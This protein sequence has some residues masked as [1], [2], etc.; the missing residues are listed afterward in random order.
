MSIEG[1]GGTKL[2]HTQTQAHETATQIHRDGVLS[3]YA[4]GCRERR[5]VCV[6]V[7]VCLL[8]VASVGVDADAWKEEAHKF[9]SFHN[10]PPSLPP[11]TPP[12]N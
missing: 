9:E 10:G 2:K 5:C 1:R 3:N 4:G 12:H 6:C 8:S 11:L 7:S